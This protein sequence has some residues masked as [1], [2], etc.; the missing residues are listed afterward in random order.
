MSDCLTSRWRKR[1]AWGE[2]EDGTATVCG[3]APR[4]GAAGQWVSPRGRGGGVV[5]RPIGVAAGQATLAAW[6]SGHRGT[7]RGSVWPHALAALDRGE[8]PA[9]VRRPRKAAWPRPLSTA[10]LATRV[11][12]CAPSPHT[13][14]TNPS[15]G[16]GRATVGVASSWFLSNS[17]APAAVGTR[18]PMFMPRR[19]VLRGGRRGQPG[20]LAARLR[21]RRTQPPTPYRTWPCGRRIDPLTGESNDGPCSPRPAGTPP[22]PPTPGPASAIRRAARSVTSC[23]PVVVSHGAVFRHV[24]LAPLPVQSLSRDGTSSGTGAARGAVEGEW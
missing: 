2:G 16:R 24:G 1:I 6:L 20:G 17:V 13:H 3:W 9:H 12:I 15:R 23:S 7:R 22:R 8:L 18:L 5:S 14:A 4:R 10:H 19:L 21:P 11:A